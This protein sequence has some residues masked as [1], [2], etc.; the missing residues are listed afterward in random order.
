ML[1]SLEGDMDEQ[2]ITFDDSDD[3]DVLV[4]VLE[5]AS[6]IEFVDVF[7]I[8]LESSEKKSIEI[9]GCCVF[10]LEG[11]INMNCV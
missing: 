7:C 10:N 1:S 8:I 3:S 6:V 11:N 4:L 2:I 5:L 9:C